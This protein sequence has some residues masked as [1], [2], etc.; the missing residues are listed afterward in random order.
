MKK[1]NSV[2]F[3]GRKDGIVIA[4]DGVIS[5]EEIKDALTQKMVDAKGF[6]KDGKTAITF[7]GRDL[8][9]A[10]E[11]DLLDIIAA[12]TDLSITFAQSAGLTDSRA[13]VTED[14]KP[15]GEEETQK[16]TIDVFSENNTVFK[17]ESLRSGQ[18]LRHAGS[19]VVVGDVNPG[20]EVIAEGNVVVLG[21]LL[22]MAHAGC[23]G[24][25]GCIVAA[26]RLQP[27]QLR[28]GDKI[29]Y[30]PKNFAKNDMYSRRPLYA[31]VKDEQI[32]VAPLL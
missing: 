26:L 23:T 5:F 18:S 29:T 9:E 14:A 12:Q 30:F 16:R 24:V 15:T 28:I 3:K 31:F 1:N 10:E 19:V 13:A 17:I 25:A 32:H 6:F 8:T 21:K 20:A 4:L 27:V 11:Q 7:K 2:L 22:G